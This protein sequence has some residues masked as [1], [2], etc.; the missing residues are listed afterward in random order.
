MQD[1]IKCAKV[2]NTSFANVPYCCLCNI[3]QSEGKVQH[4]LVPSD[5]VQIIGGERRGRGR[6]LRKSAL[7]VW[8]DTP[9]T[10]TLE[11]Q[12]KVNF[13]LRGGTCYILIQELCKKNYCF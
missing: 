4:G 13:T 5:I 2:F 9:F 3:V 12:L 1:F 6:G 8:G 7:Y 11:H 10:Y